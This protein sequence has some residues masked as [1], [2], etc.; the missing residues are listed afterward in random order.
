MGVTFVEPNYSVYD[1]E[2]YLWD[3]AGDGAIYDGTDNAFN[4]AMDNYD[5]D[6]SRYLTVMSGRFFTNLTNI[7]YSGIMTQRQV[8]V[9]QNDG[10]ARFYD[11]L[12]NVSDEPVTYT[13]EVNTGFGSSY[14]TVF[15]TSNGD[16][17][18]TSADDWVVGYSADGSTTPAGFVFGD[19]SGT[20]GADLTYNYSTLSYEVTITLA[21]NEVAGFLTFGVQGATQAEV[22]ASL[23]ELRDLPTEALAGLT[24]FEIESIVNWDV[25]QMALHLEGTNGNDVL[26]G[27]STNDSLRGLKGN[28][29]LIGGDGSD[30]LLGGLGK[31]TVYGGG[32][33]DI[34]LGDGSIVQVTTSD[35]ATDSNGEQFSISLTMDD[36]G[37]G[38][39]TKISGFLSR[40]EITSEEVDVMF[41]IDVS[42]STSSAFNG[43]VD[44]GDRNGDGYSNTV[45]DAEIASF[46][47]LHASIVNDANLPNAQI[48]IAP[49][50]GSVSLS[51]TF[52]ANEDTNNNGIADVVEYVRALES[53]GGTDFYETLQ[54]A[55]SHFGS[56]DSGQKVLYFLS[57][58]EDG[59]YG[60]LASQ[61]ELL[62]DDDVLIQSFGVGSDASEEDLDV[63]DDTLLNGTTTIVL[64]PSLLSDELLDPGIDASD[65]K[66]IRVYLNGKSVAS[67]DPDD[68][69]STPLGL[70]YF[71]LELK[72]LKAKA[73][74]VIEIRAVAKDG[75]KTLVS[76]SQVLE[77]YPGKDGGDVLRGGVGDDLF[78]GGLGNDTLNGGAGND[79]MYGNE[80]KDTASYAGAESGVIVDLRNESGHDGA[81]I[82]DT[83]ISIENLT[84]GSYGDELTGDGGVNVLLGRRGEDILNGLGKNDVLAG[85]KGDDI[86][87]GGSG[88][89]RFIFEIGD[90]RD[91]ITDFEV[92]KKGEKIDL[93]DFDI[94]S[95]KD[96]KD[97][98][99]VKSGDTEIRFDDGDTLVIV[100]TLIKEFSAGDFLL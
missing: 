16:A 4:Y 97:L 65:I 53:N 70:R 15:N 1:G 68:L 59:S 35:T 3:I 37:S 47:A 87:T 77:H 61:S 98:M 42:G 95:F 64:D 17:A 29:V 75:V 72:G 91:T 66:S 18:V 55:V 50:N 54:A 83:L 2:G 11:I 85:G 84:G 96:L 88:N 81:A 58:G 60:D 23:E 34:L 62:L 27:V 80:G 100:D 56:S 5:L 92:K 94:D 76:T 19:V 24:A 74:D 28:D 22:A 31:D 45:L 48:T 79:Y 86:L 82:G 41:A 6:T 12:I 36:A 52:S 25:P 7:T 99:K 43:Q 63:V 51:Q 30:I 8:Y 13:Y 38:K 90:G 73:D 67:I 26:T 40:Q 14:N 9:S 71:D 69:V 49:F 93:R 39:T 57:D 89:D 21:P 46:E 33:D 32:G 78:D 44:V 20:S 10:Y